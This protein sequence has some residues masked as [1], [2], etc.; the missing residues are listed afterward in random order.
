MAVYT[1]VYVGAL[2]RGT[3]DSKLPINEFTF[4]VS[5]LGTTFPMIPRA[6]CMMAPLKI[7]TI[8]AATSVQ[9]G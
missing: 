3:S 8:G 4:P 9:T 1:K 6:T 7:V 2:N 5:L